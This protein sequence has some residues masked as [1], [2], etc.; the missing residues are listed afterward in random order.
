MP[1]RTGL[2]FAQ[3]SLLDQ[4]DLPKA[5][6]VQAPIKMRERKVGHTYHITEH[7]MDHKDTNSWQPL[8]MSDFA[9]Q[10]LQDYWRANS[11][12]V[13]FAEDSFFIRFGSRLAFGC[14]HRI[15]PLDWFQ[16]DIL[17]AVHAE[18]QGGFRGLNPPDVGIF[19]PYGPM[20]TSMTGR[21]KQLNFRN[22]YC[23]SFL[24]LVF[25]SFN[26]LVLGNWESLESQEGNWDGSDG[27]RQ[28][29]HPI[30]VSDRM[31]FFLLVNHPSISVLPYFFEWVLQFAMQS[32]LVI[33]GGHRH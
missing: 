8:K 24:F 5:R 18:P 23:I 3:E 10:N 19:W 11:I 14:W 4:V 21:S 20:M 15:Y 2:K 30:N 1:Y 28:P 29:L 9:S 26:S 17:H 31:C 33:Y 16:L 25:F 7:W 12:S 13:F 32:M 6:M 22:T 27:S